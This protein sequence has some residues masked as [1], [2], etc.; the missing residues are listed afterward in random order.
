LSDL[1]LDRAPDAVT[2]TAKIFMKAVVRGDVYLHFEDEAAAIRGL[3]DA[4]FDGAELTLPSS[5]DGVD[6]TSGVD[7]NHIVRAM[8]AKR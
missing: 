8:T 7:R 3:K 4:G 2:A 1:H 6:V 5:F